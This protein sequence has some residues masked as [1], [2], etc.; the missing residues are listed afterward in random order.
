MR[1]NERAGA[2][3]CKRQGANSSLATG[4]GGGQL[5]A[6][7]GV[8]SPRDGRAKEELNSSVTLAFSAGVMLSHLCQHLVRASLV[9]PAVANGWFLDHACMTEFT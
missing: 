1:A 4:G 6:A 8:L 7:S 2:P 3:S 9:E 5:I